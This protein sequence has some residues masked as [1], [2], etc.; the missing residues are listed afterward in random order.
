ML[1]WQR[2]CSKKGKGNVQILFSSIC[3]SQACTSH[4]PKYVTLSSPASLWEGT[5]KGMGVG[6][7]HY[8]NSQVPF[9]KLTT[10]C[11]H[12]RDPLTTCTRCSYQPRIDTARSL[13]FLAPISHFCPQFM[14]LKSFGY[15]VLIKIF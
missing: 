6:R 3:L 5:V 15:S 14:M 8:S 7:W 12:N 10:Y 4:W 2:Q 13:A 9:G 1:S 11:L